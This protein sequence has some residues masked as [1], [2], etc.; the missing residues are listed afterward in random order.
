MAGQRGLPAFLVRKLLRLILVILG[1]TALVFFLL[2]AV[3]GD[4]IRARY[5]VEAGLSTDDYEA[6]RAQY[7]LDR[8]VIV[9]YGIWLEHVSKGDM[10]E[11]I[12]QRRD[13]SGL[14]W[15]SG[16]VTLQVQTASLIIA[17]AVGI[18]GGCLAAMKAGT[19]VDRALS[20]V[21]QGEELGRAEAQM[22]LAMAGVKP[23]AADQAAQGVQDGPRFADRVG[24][25]RA[26]ALHFS[27][28]PK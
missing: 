1:V 27:W 15:K 28:A 11:S 25:G 12:T 24:A 26:L 16:K 7:G 23:E 9:Q 13:V 5:G 17:L 21:A 2:R 20:T 6:L 19:I 18:S 3:P 22:G 14:L 4:P 10:G 8:P